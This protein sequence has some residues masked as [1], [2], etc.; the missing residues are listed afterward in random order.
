M[1]TF[2]TLK[3]EDKPKD[4]YKEYL[5]EFNQ[6][7]NQRLKETMSIDVEEERLKLNLSPGDDKVDKSCGLIDS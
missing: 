2:K 1:Q 6:Q 4:P 3:D 5:K 7:R